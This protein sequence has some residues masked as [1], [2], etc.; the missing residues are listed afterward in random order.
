MCV[1]QHIHLTPF[2]FNLFFVILKVDLHGLVWYGCFQRFRSFLLSS[3]FVF[4]VFKFIISQKK[5]PLKTPCVSGAIDLP[6][7]ETETQVGRGRG[8]EG[9]G[10][11]CKFPGQIK[12]STL[13]HPNTWV[14]NFPPGCYQV[15][16]QEIYLFREIAREERKKKDNLLQH[17]DSDDAL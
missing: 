14:V 10:D 4:I 15:P 5:S 13:M 11:Q 1:T 2:Q 9:G 3:S 7:F 8:R 12:F 16:P 6:C 17:S